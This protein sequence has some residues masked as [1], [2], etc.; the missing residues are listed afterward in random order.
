MENL[1]FFKV[2]VPPIEK[3]KKTKSGESYT[4][5]KRRFI[6]SIKAFEMPESF[7]GNTVEEAQAK[8]KAIYE[9]VALFEALTG[10]F[11]IVLTVVRLF[12]KGF[13]LAEI[14]KKLYNLAKVIVSLFETKAVELEKNEICKNWLE[15]SIVKKI[16]ENNKIE[17]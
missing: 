14:A 11:L 5:Q 13:S 8:S 10:N 1:K 12:G 16:L 15:A 4:Q 9:K 3:V 2:E 7:V 17:K 6:Q